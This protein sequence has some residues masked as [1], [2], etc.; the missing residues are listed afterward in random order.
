MAS[1]IK[2]SMAAKLSYLNDEHNCQKIMW[3]HHKVRHILLNYRNVSKVLTKLYNDW[4]YTLL[5]ANNLYNEY[6]SIDDVNNSYTFMKKLVDV[7]NNLIYILLND[8]YF[9]EHR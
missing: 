8:I 9:N 4:L 1:P 3:L 5:R 2:L 7:D 6:I